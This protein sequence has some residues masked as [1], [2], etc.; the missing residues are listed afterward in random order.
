MAKRKRKN[1]AE[2]AIAAFVVI[3]TILWIFNRQAF[4]H[5]LGRVA[6]LLSVIAVIA[7]AAIILY[8]LIVRWRR[9]NARSVTQ[10]APDAKTQ[11]ES[12]N[13]TPSKAASAYS[14]A[15][16]QGLEDPHAADAA[17]SLKTWSL[18]LIRK[19]EWKR[20]EMLCAGFYEAKGYRPQTTR[21]G[22]DGGIDI[23]LYRKAGPEVFGIVQCKAW[24]TQPVG[25]KP[26][27]ELY[28]VKAAENMPLAVFI[29]SCDYTE[30][31]KTFAHG[32]A[33]QLITGDKLL[34]L[35]MDLPEQVSS[36]L[37]RRVTDGDYTTPTCPSCDLK[38]VR[39]KTGKG[40]FVGREFWGCP[41]YPRCRQTL[42][43]SALTS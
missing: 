16:A 43:I 40:P 10:S 23:L 38:M 17:S 27:R 2:E 11:T 24:N 1:A 41:Q 15:F 12:G 31:A 21:T 28:G 7:A 34:K 8:L 5:I 4:I 37:L 13:R 20:F 42:R 25:V 29:T 30:D 9:N 22:A 39:R 36:G 14:D 19:L 3:L 32:K 26:A 35:L 6:S 33:L 18:E